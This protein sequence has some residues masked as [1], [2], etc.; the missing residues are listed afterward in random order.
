MVRRW[1][2][3]PV[4]LKLSLSDTIANPIKSHVDG[5][6]APLFDRVGGDSAGSVVVGDNRRGGLGV[7]HFFEGNP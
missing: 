2:F 6:G 7:P 5:F 4:D 1:M 3:S